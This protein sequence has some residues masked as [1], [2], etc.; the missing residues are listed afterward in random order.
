MNILILEDEPDV[1]ELAVKFLTRFLPPPQHTYFVAE[2]LA[3][4]REAV[5]EQDVSLALFDYQLPDGSGTELVAF[6]REIRPAC[7]IVFASGR[8][9]SHRGFEP[10]EE[11]VAIRN[12]NPDGVLGKPFR[13]EELEAILR[14]LEMIS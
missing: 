7:K 8:V 10:T 12:S 5:Q 2:N 1:L 4:G 13:M 6:T 9:V 14:Q 3:Q 11:E